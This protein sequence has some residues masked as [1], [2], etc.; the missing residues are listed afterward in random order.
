MGN[1]S[2]NITGLSLDQN[3][4]S[5]LSGSSTETGISI[6]ELYDY[7]YPQ[8]LEWILI[9]TYALTFVVG[10]VG[11]ILVCFAVWINKDLRTITNIFMVNLSIA[12]LLI[13]IFCLPSALLVDVTATWFLGTIACKIHIFLATLT[14]SVSVMTLCAISVERWYAICHPLR[15]HSTVRRARYIIIIIWI[16]SACIAVPELI[17]STVVP[18]REDTVLLSACYPALWDDQ[19]I[20][21]FQICLMV[22]LYFL[23]IA[24]MAFSYSHIGL[25]LWRGSIS[26]TI[27]LR[28]RKPMI[29]GG[30]R[31]HENVGQSEGR[32]KA[33]RMLVAVV[34]VFAICFLPNHTLN[35][36]RY[37]GQLQNVPQKRL[38]A[39]FAH[40]ATFFNSCIN[41]VIYNFMSEAFRK[42]FRDV[43]LRSCFRCRKRRRQWQG[44]SSYH[45][46][47]TGSRS[48]GVRFSHN[49]SV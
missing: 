46:T 1:Y 35:I 24:M 22:G 37:T 19:S 36:L 40:W 15:F 23:P 34:V 44:P 49:I 5:F 42:A 45:M 41:P 17:T 20:V 25:V 32:R 9:V 43:A 12:D 13:I 30:I 16:A 18:L 28:A 39:L 11:N 38:I 4:S 7:I 31:V 2:E 29:N 3:D 27:E 8:T 33:I 48:L 10:V 21:I 26:E 6:Q 47:F 14:I